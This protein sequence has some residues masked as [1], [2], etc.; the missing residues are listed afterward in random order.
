LG[1]LSLVVLALNPFALLLVLPSLHVWLWLPHVRD[2]PAWIR[3]GVLVAGLA[4]PALLVLSFAARLDLGLGTFWYLTALVSVGYVQPLAVGV[5]LAWTA[6]AA[7]LAALAVHRYAPYP[8]AAE[9]PPRGPIREVVRRAVLAVRARR[10]DG[11]D[12]LRALPG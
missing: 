9:R 11:D 5:A 12:E 3:L 8:A 10:R 6:A 1:V 2:R 4:G 7:Q